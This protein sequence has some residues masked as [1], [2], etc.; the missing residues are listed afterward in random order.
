MGLGFATSSD[1]LSGPAPTLSNLMSFATIAIFLASQGHLTLIAMIVDS[2]RTIPI[3]STSLPDNAMATFGT[4]LFVGAVSI[5]LP[6]T[7][8]LVIVQIVLAL[9]AKAAP[10]LNLFAVGLPFTQLAG[11]ALLVL[12][13]PAMGSAI[14]EQITASLTLVAP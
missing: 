1:G 8:A 5:A 14:G 9:I 12:A 11:A 13:F 6:V 10:A 3:G 2:F 4:A 7:F